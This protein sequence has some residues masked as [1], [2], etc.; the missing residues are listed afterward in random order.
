MRDVYWH[1]MKKI[2]LEQLTWLKEYRNYINE[3]GGLMPEIAKK[4]EEKINEAKKYRFIIGILIG[5]EL[6][7]AQLRALVVLN[8]Y[9]SHLNKLV[10]LQGEYIVS[11]IKTYESYSY[12]TIAREFCNK[13]QLSQ[14]DPDLNKE[15]WILNDRRNDVVHDSIFT[16]KGDLDKSDEE[17]REYVVSQAVHN[18]LQKLITKLNIHREENV[19]SDK[20]IKELG[21]L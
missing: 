20:Q 1:K 19:V 2:T 7:K 6:I 13:Y 9:I 18:I 15:I 8:D 21:L 5:T 11:K 17:V 12:G 14:T 3:I 16:F 4:S 10:E